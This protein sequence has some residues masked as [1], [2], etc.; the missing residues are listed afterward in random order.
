MIRV[1]IKKLRDEAVIPSYAHDGDSCVDLYSIDEAVLNP[2]SRK[3]IS[4]GL[5]MAIPK[6]Y[7]GLIR[8]RSGNAL[9]RGV[10]VLNT[11]GTIDSNYR[12][13]IG[14]ILYNSTPDQIYIHVG[15]R[16]AQ[17][18]FKE[19]SKVEFDIRNELDE[20]DRGDGGFGST[21]M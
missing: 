6:G 21:G 1:K 8:P 13:E 20:T 5:S 4:T 10:T 15:D 9:K 12:G 3:L 18:A 7:E 11:P 17:M 19:V 16:I 14:V 2:F